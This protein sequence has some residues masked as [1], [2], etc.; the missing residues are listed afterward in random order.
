ME[1]YSDV[2]KLYNGVLKGYSGV[3]ELEFHA[4]LFF[5]FYFLKFDR[6]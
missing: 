1:P 5:I 4:I 3:L 2:V 6:A